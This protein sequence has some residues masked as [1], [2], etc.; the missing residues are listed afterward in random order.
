MIAESTNKIELIWYN[1]LLE[2]YEC[3]SW[4]RFNNLNRES[5]EEYSIL[6]ET[7]DLTARIANKIVGELN[8]ARSENPPVGLALSYA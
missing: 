5:Q 8:A 3:G 7:S 1:P 2:I 4:V 6:Y